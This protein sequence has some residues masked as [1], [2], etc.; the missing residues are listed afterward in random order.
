[1]ASDITL[2]IFDPRKGAMARKRWL[3]MSRTRD[4]ARRVLG[5]ATPIRRGYECWTNIAPEDAITIVE[6]TYAEARYLGGAHPEEIR[7]YAVE[8]PSPMYWWIIEH[9]F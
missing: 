1:M 7:Q 2:L 4:N 9:D 8:F 6:S 5:N 3:G